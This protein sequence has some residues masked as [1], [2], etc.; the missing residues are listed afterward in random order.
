MAGSGRVSTEIDSE[1]QY[2]LA[3]K[4]RKLESTGFLID[5][6]GSLSINQF[7]ALFESEKN[8]RDPL[9]D[10][11]LDRTRWTVEGCHFLSMAQL[12]SRRADRTRDL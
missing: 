7:R 4:E 6:R 11:S 9:A 10:E 1:S 12:K 2:G 3:G 5:T 8:A